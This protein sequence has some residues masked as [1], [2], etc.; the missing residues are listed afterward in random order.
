MSFICGIG[1]YYWIFTF[2]C[3]L[4]LLFCVVLVGGYEYY[5]GS[6]GYT[7]G[8]ERTIIIAFSDNF[9]YCTLTLH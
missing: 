5:L 4:Q 8:K 9:G 3:T 7:V 6:P 2:D 1:E